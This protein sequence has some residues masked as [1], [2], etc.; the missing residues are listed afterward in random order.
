MH[1]LNG[2]ATPVWAEPA[3]RATPNP[4]PAEPYFATAPDGT[5]R[6]C[7]FHAPTAP[8]RGL[9]LHL[10]PFA[11]EMNKSRRMAA[12]QSHALAQAGFAVLQFDLLGC[13][14][15][16]GDF[17]DATWPAW[18]ADAQ[19]AVQRLNQHAAA[20]A[21]PLWL[22]G[23]RVGALLAVQAAERLTRAGGAPPRL[24]LWQPSA[25]GKT[26]LQ[27]FLRLKAAAEMLDG[28][29]K[30]V[31]ESLKR[32]LA[33]GRPVEVAGY[34]LHPQLAA[35]LEA[36]T[37]TPP[38]QLARAVWLEVAGSDAPEL[39]PASRMAIEHWRAAG[40][41]VDAEAVGG[42]AFW[43]TTEIEDAFALLARTTLA[44]QA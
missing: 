23:H 43:Q 4:M 22:W 38:P 32:E 10:H 37:L 39:L 24:L 36:A 26:A 42:P 7:I 5:A 33:A 29:A 9:V 3:G 21:A 31:T 18:L 40:W 30:G 27:Q 14:D 13:G 11:E 25:S 8:L 17:G 1:K 16:A 28:G 15:S 44:L 34:R 12:Q 19:W 2:Y 35:G 6:F 41:Q 20:P